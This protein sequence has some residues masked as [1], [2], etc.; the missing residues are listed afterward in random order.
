M[1][2]LQQ[3]ECGSSPGVSTSAE[4]KFCGR[5]CGLTSD[6]PGVVVL[7]THIPVRVTFKPVLITLT[8][9]SKVCIEANSSPTCIR[10]TWMHTF[11]GEDVDR[12]LESAAQAIA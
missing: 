4:R 3:Y 10:L 5:Q 9:S 12:R 7:S 6:R 1:I 8:Q 11:S 2:D